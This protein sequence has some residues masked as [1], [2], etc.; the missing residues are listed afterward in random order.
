MWEAR[1]G[2]RR[3]GAPSCR[4]VGGEVCYGTCNSQERRVGVRSVAEAGICSVK[5]TFRGLTKA[6]EAL[7]SHPC[8]FCEVLG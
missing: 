2:H 1:G 6:E 3:C 5:T 8:S 7:Q 4:M